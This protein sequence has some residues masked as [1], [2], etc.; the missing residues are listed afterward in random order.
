[1]EVNSP[2]AYNP[3]TGLLYVPANNNMCAKMPAGED[4]TYKPGELFIGFSLEGILT[5]VRIPEPDQTIGELQAWDL[6]TG[7]LVWV[8]K[9]E[10]FLW[11]PLLTTA[12]NLVFA[13]GTSDR[14]F[15][16]FN[17]KDGTLLWEF[18]APSGVIGVPTSYEVDGEQYIAVQS[19]WGVDADRIQ[20]ALNHIMPDRKLS[21]PHGGS[22]HVFKL[23]PQSSLTSASTA[24]L[25]QQ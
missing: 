9:Y 18:P 25:P 21:I 20:G 14:K 7:E 23:K 6:K 12:G 5:S 8:H 24:G 16:A 15:R 19:G 22:I 1:M 4:A 3:D 10:S 17:A 11:A 2:E 13:G